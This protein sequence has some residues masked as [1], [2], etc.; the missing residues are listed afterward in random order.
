MVNCFDLLYCFVNPACF[1]ALLSLPEMGAVAH[2]ITP[3]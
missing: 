1:I 2:V 3:F